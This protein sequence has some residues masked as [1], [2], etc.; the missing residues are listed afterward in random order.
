MLK[1]VLLAFVLAAIPLT[2]FLAILAATGDDSS[3]EG[4]GG[5]LHA[6][7]HEK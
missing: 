7:A 1:D 5:E 2:Y 3:G 4:D 6:R